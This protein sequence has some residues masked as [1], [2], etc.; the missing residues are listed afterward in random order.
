LP[1]FVSH[2]VRV[3]P[4]FDAAFLGRLARRY[5]T[6][7]DEVLGGARSEADLGPALGGGLTEG[8]VQ[9]LIEREWA[10]APEDVLWRRTKCGLHMTAAER[11]ASAKRIAELL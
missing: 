3:H 11:A 9:Y 6:L 10:R 8:E 1:G 5:G 7:V 4:D 2:L